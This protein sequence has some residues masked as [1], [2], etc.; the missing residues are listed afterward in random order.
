M[1]LQARLRA[2]VLKKQLT[3]KADK[4][5]EPLEGLAFR[6]YEG[7]W[8]ILPDFS[9]EKP[10]KEG[11]SKDLDVKGLSD[12]DDHYGFVFE[13]YLTVPETDVYTLVTYSDDGSALYIDNEM[14]VENDGLHE[15]VIKQGF[16]AL[17]KGSHKIKVHYFDAED[18]E[19]LRIG[20][21]REGMTNLERIPEDWL[22]H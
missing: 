4:P 13:G 18:G 12:K 15:P 1:V 10:L 14:V 21:F 20:Y 17:E 11:V 2:E 6:Y 7:E 16:I 5:R 8:E 9:K 19:I 22:K 3:R